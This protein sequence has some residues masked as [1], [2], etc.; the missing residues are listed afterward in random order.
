MWNFLKTHKYLITL[1]WFGMV[2]AISFMEA[3]LK[4]Q[5]E[6]VDRRIGVSIG[7]IIFTALNRVEVTFLLIY[8]I[9]SLASN[10]FRRSYLLHCLILIVLIQTIFLLP[11]LDDRAVQI[12]NQQP[13]ED[14]SLHISYVLLEIIK[15]I[16]LLWVSV[17]EIKK[18]ASYKSNKSKQVQEV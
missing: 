1:I 2:L 14:S 6:L 16:V 4:F 8:T 9:L 18:L 10:S 17:S 12:I 13:V 15:V 5:S 7:K 3:P 11:L